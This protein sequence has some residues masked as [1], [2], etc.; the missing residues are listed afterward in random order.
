MPD[1]SGAL[2][3][4][5]GIGLDHA[6]FGESRTTHRERLGDYEAFERVPGAGMTDMYP[7]GIVMLSYDE[8]DHLNF[9]EIGGET[10]AVLN[11]IQV[12]GRS[13]GAV[14]DELAQGGLH[15]EFD[16]DSSY[17]ISS[18]GVELFTSSPDNLNEPVEGVSISPIT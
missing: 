13:L 5:P 1:G 6:R 10:I 17:L 14:L 9:I 15:V 16:G 11:G 8:S 3:V 18:T 12:T 7:D 4:L 2:E